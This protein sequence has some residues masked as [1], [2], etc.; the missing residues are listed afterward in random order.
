MKIAFVIGSAISGKFNGL[1]VQ[2]AT[3]SDGLEK[4]GH[5]VVLISPWGHYDWKAFDIIH[6]VGYGTWLEIVEAIKSRTNAK[7]VLSPSIDSNRAYFFMKLAS[8]VGTKL[9][10]ITSPLHSLRS[11]DK[12]ISK[13]HVRSEYEETYLVKSLG[14]DKSRIEKI[15]LS[16]RFAGTKSYSKYSRE[17]F[18]LHVSI[19]SSENKN[20]RRLIQA[21]IKYKF[22]LVLA[23]SVGTN[24]FKRELEEAIASHENIEYLGFV[25]EERLLELYLRA[26]VFALPSL[27]EGVGLVALEAASMGADVVLTDR[28]APKEYYHG[29]AFLVD[30]I[31]IDEIGLTIERVIAGDTF[32][33][34]LKCFIHQNYNNSK[35]VQQL[36]NT[37]SE[38]L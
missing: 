37:Y 24:N 2:I 34:K 35:L 12:F 20:V 4:I 5:D 3:W 6:V 28:G 15:P 11:V 19:L 25:S 17:D 36:A 30:P 1:R 26:R 33:P 16:C 14:I 13:Y 22:R 18:C 10:N 9:L 21:A 31:D 32:Q 23:G 38:V 7:V 27:F 29:K 8:Y